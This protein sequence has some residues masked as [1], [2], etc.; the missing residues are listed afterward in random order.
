[1][2]ARRLEYRE[3]EP[4]ATL[5]SSRSLIG[6]KVDLETFSLLTLLTP[7]LAQDLPM[8]YNL[9]SILRRH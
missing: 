8:D 9:S 5:Q 3:A 2:F 4:G 7:S 6:F 1:M